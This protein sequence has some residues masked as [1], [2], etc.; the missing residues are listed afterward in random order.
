MQDSHLKV[1]ATLFGW[2]DGMSDDETGKRERVQQ[3]IRPSEQGWGIRVLL[4]AVSKRKWEEK[5][6][7]KFPSSYSSLKNLNRKL[8]EKCHVRMNEC[9]S[10]RFPV[11]EGVDY[12]DEK[13]FSSNGSIITGCLLSFIKIFIS[14]SWYKIFGFSF[15]CSRGMCD[16][17]NITLQSKL[18]NNNKE[19]RSKYTIHGKDEQTKS[20]I[21][22]FNED[23]A[24]HDDYPFTNTPLDCCCREKKDDSSNRLPVLQEKS[25]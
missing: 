10:Q 8:W 13:G 1:T 2:W 5:C 18:L 20:R 19:W 11:K 16:S 15:T 14:H 24:N 23:D 3:T 4:C 12:S 17:W 21:S 6:W 9:E 22:L 7:E 25:H